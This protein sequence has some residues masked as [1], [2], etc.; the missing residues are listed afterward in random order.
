MD[1]VKFAELVA[2]TGRAFGDVDGYYDAQERDFVTLFVG[3]LKA[4]TNFV[5]DVKEVINKANSGS[6]N[7][8][9]LIEET[10]ALLADLPEDKR[11]ATVESMAA[12]IKTVINRD[13]VEASSETRNF[14]NWKKALM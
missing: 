6:C 7:I 9:Q 12:F 8:P 1:S 5:G 10:K 11:K 14:E 13:G 2:R 3:F 4:N